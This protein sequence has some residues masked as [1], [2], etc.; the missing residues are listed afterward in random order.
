M[1]KIKDQFCITL[2]IYCSL[3]GFGKFNYILILI[4]G[5]IIT[6]TS[7]ETIGIGFV[8]PVAECDLQLSTQQKG[9][10][11]SIS[12]IGIIISSHTWGFI[13]D[14][15]GRKS[16][17]VPSLI[18]SFIS[19]LLSSLSVDFNMLVVLRFFSGFLYVK[20]S[21]YIFEC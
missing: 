8:F 16:V 19:T 17:I 18:M 21:D 10:L 7:F 6:A 13:S 12:S 11:S 1:M 3:S 4:S 2:D 5:I 20:H 9:I 14:C 15:R